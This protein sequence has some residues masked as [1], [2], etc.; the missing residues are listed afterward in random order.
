MHSFDDLNSVWMNPIKKCHIKPEEEE[1]IKTISST[2]IDE[3][4]KTIHNFT[5]II[6]C[7]YIFSV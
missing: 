1:Y 4:S 6:A 7:H 2:L 5:N 3:F